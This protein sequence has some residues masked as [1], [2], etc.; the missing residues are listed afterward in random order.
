M[1]VRML[2]ALVL[3]LSI[4]SLFAQERFT[5]AKDLRGE[6]KSYEDG[7]YRSVDD[8]PFAGL[9]TIY[10]QL[11]PTRST[12]SRLRIRSSGSYFLFVN[13]KLTGEFEG[14]KSFALDSLFNER[15][16]GWVAIHQDRINERDLLTELLLHDVKSSEDPLL[17]RAYDY[18][19]DFVVIAGLVLIILFIVVFRLNPKLAGDYFAV[20]RIFASREADDGQARLTDGSNIQ[21]YV[22]C[23]LLVGYYLLIV[24]RNLPERYMLPLQF[25]MSGFWMMCFQWIKLSAIVFLALSLKVL[26]IF[27]LTRLFNIQGLARFHFFNWIRLLLVTIGAATAVLF[28]YF[29]SRGSSPEYYVIFLFAIAVVLASWVVIAFLKL[30]G[31]TGH[32]MFHLFSYLCATEIIP[33]LITVK[34]LYNS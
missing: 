32:S 30:S 33:L 29:V 1:V 10:L 19:K 31:R 21:F 20:N 22:L 2:S 23:S 25:P 3:T 15:R 5:V 27:S 14:A 11:D 34:V 26:I 28:T 24:I 7:E 16:A 18:F 4:T 17:P 8:M 6:W 9:R 13:G 12:G